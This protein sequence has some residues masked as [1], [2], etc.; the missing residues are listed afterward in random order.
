MAFI[1]PKI[2]TKIPTGN[3]DFDPL[4]GSYIAGGSGCVVAPRGGCGGNGS[5][6]AN[7]NNNHPIIHDGIDRDENPDSTKAERLKSIIA[8]YYKR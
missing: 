1:S 3:I 8:H 5:N 7:I 4:T 2:S 6:V